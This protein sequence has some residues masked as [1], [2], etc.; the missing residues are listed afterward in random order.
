MED[1]NAN[2]IPLLDM[3]GPRKRKKIVDGSSRKS[4]MW[5]LYRCGDYHITRKEKFIMDRTLRRWA[6]LIAALGT[7]GVAIIIVLVH[8]LH[9]LGHTSN[10]NLRIC[11]V[12]ASFN[13]IQFNS[14]C[15]I[16]LLVSDVSLATL[17]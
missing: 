14:M 2:Y 1:S 13:S 10:Q 17:E 7:L 8:I 4:T 15:V 16:L 3:S 11:G 6:L 12:Y 5:S 9:K